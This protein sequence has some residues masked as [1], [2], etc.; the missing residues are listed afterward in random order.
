LR[1]IQILTPQNILIEHEHAGVVLRAL[2]FILDQFFIILFFLIN[3]LL[4]VSFELSGAVLDMYAYIVIIPV[5]F[6]YSLLFESF[7]Y[8]QTLGK[9]VVGIKVRRLDGN[10]IT[11]TEAATRWL[12]RIPDIFLSAGALA[13]ILINS[14]E[15]QQRM[16]D[17][18]AGTIV[19]RQSPASG[20]KIENLLKLNATNEYQPV[21]PQ[22]ARLDEDLVVMVKHAL[23]RY[24]RYQNAAHNQAVD[25]LADKLCQILEIEHINET[26]PQFLRTIIRDYIVLTR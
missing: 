21:Y 9:R 8:G 22:V 18:L 15:R 3:F 2:S 10:E 5:Y 14:T 20:L 26:K 4:L 16:G 13:A 7:M 6:L 12:M 23:L 17:I 19:I 25:K 11:F 1:N 24:N